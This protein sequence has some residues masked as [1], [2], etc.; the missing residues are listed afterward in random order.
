MRFEDEHYVKLYTRDTPTWKAMS[1]QAKALWPL[2]MRRLDT[3]GS[4]DCGELGRVETVSVMTDLPGEVVEPGL[5]DLERVKVVTWRRGDVLLA[6]KFIEAQEAR[7]T[8]KLRKAEE[9]QKARA[10]LA[11]QGSGIIN[12]VSE[13][14]RTR[15]GASESVTPCHPPSSSPSPTSSPTPSPIPTRSET[16]S[17][18]GA[19]E[20]PLQ[21]TDAA[22]EVFTYWQKVMKKP[23]TSRLTDDRRKAVSARLKDGYSVAQIKRAIDG[24]SKT[25]HNCGE[26]A[27]HTR[28]DD[29]ELICRNG[30]NLERF[31]ANAESNGRSSNGRPEP[32]PYTGGLLT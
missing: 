16:G 9:R 27:N 21:G 24:C 2:L 13:V 7:K 10:V 29:L 32:V 17:T 20:L 8:E 18:S 1:W 30:S 19:S 23:P 12:D 22:T 26:N 4:M 6:P 3:V 14:V 31:I 11:A 15:P 28:Y 25:P 5:K